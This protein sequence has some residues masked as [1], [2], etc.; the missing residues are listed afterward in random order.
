MKELESRPQRTRRL[1]RFLIWTSCDT[2][3]ENH[4]TLSTLWSLESFQIPFA[5]TRLTSQT[6]H[7]LP[8]SQPPPQRPAS[9]CHHHVSLAPPK[10][11]PSHLQRPQQAPTWSTTTFQH[12]V[13]RCTHQ[14]QRT[15]P[16]QQTRPRRWTWQPNGE[17]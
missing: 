3:I 12:H 15:R 6:I 16:H 9:P 7:A 8:L 4:L 2:T 14:P 10:S 13:S 1:S 5:L 17:R 11:V